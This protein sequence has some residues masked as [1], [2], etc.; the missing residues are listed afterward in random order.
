MSAARVGRLVGCGVVLALVGLSQEPGVAQA[1]APAQP[2]LTRDLTVDA[3]AV[4]TTTD[5]TLKPGDRVV[6]R[7]TGTARCGDQQTFG[8]AGLPRGFRDLLRVLPMAQAGRGA[9]IGRIGD[10]DAALPFM[11]GASGEMVSTVAGPLALGVNRAASDTC[12]TP[13]SVHV[14]VFDPADGAADR[15]S[16][17]LNSSHT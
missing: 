12:H 9:L 8:P 11:I 16:T 10:G 1:P 4:W 6:F 7:A 15:K 13:F 17:R 14:D 2:R 3:Q 5:L